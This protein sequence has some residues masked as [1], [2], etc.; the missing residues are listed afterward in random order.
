MRQPI[1]PVADDAPA[2]PDDELKIG[3]QLKCF[4]EGRGRLWGRID[5]SKGFS[6][7]WFLSHMDL[8]VPSEH[9]Q[10]GKRY[11][12]E[13][14]LNHFYSASRLWV[15]PT[16]DQQNE[17]EMATISI[18]LEAYDN[19]EPYPFLDRLICE[20]RNTEEN[21]RAECD[22]PSAPQYPGC[23]PNKRGYTPSPTPS[24]TEA[25]APTDDEGRRGRRLGEN[26][27]RELMKWAGMVAGDQPRNTSKPYLIMDDENWRP[28]DWTDEEWEVWAEAK[29]AFDRGVATRAQHQLLGE[30]EA[31]GVEWSKTKR[32]YEEKGD[33]E[34]ENLSD[35]ERK[36]LA[37]DNLH[38]H[39]YQFLIDAKTEYYF[40]YQGT[41]TIPPCY[42]EHEQGS[43]ATTNHWR[44]IKDPIRVHPRQIDELQRLIRERID[45][46][47]CRGS[48]AAKV[49]RDGSVSVARPLMETTFVHYK[50]FCECPNWRS[51]WPEDKQWC[52]MTKDGRGEYGEDQDFRYKDHPYWFD[53][54][55][56]Y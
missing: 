53:T 27:S 41:S 48:T 32:V 2:N 34:R 56:D 17:N 18:F 29:S 31:S 23:F 49:D 28:A 19:I 44:I 46:D 21:V 50:T 35:Q 26:M 45:P 47:K 33:D 54:G 36:L 12:A 22:M 14:Q 52:R 43:R 38:F 16:D 24:P 40:R 42:G 5:F 4:L 11:S 9:V 37:G 55:G 20:W 25:D 39:N 51:K 1:E 8:K 30:K 10:E 6:K 3:Y 7:W 13:V 15:D